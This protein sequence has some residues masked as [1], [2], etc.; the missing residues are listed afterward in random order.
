M[1][2]P[3][4]YLVL[5]V[6]VAAAFGG[7]RQSVH[8][9]EPV[10]SGTI[11]AD[12]DRGTRGGADQR[13]SGASAPDTSP[14]SDRDGASDIGSDLGGPQ[15]GEICGLTAAESRIVE[16]ILRVTARS[17]YR[18]LGQDGEMR[19]T[20]ELFPGGTRTDFRI[21]SADYA[22]CSAASSTCAS[23]T[24]DCFGRSC[25]RCHAIECGPGSDYW[26]VTVAAAQ[27]DGTSGDALRYTTDDW[28]VNYPT[29]PGPSWELNL[30]FADSLGADTDW[31][32]ELF[33][34]SRRTG[35]EY[36]ASYEAQLGG[37]KT[38]A[39]SRPS[40]LQVEVV[41]TG[42]ADTG[43]YV[44]E[45]KTD[46]TVRPEGRLV[47]YRSTGDVTREVLDS[48]TVKSRGRQIEWTGACPQ[49]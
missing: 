19:P 2:T 18:T 4:R 20:V 27:S 7:C 42:L 23:E 34:T 11:D 40:D 41:L 9:G 5:G 36:D 29:A 8:L 45:P 3:L 26:T 35:T 22:N 37:E 38:D 43:R 10:S 24:F 32:Q 16:G 31:S 12:P 25:R 33:V 47:Y 44:L 13:D 21:E 30:A 48:Y 14:R 39:E 1:R 6:L 28:R 46:F 17:L 15:S 49:E